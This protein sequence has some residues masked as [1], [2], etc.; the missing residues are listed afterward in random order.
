M[1]TAKPDDRLVALHKKKSWFLGCC[2]CT[3]YSNVSQASGEVGRGG[4]GLGWSPVCCPLSWR[5][6]P[7]W[8]PFRLCNSL[9]PSI[10]ALH[11]SFYLA[12]CF[13]SPSI[14]ALG[15]I[16]SRNGGPDKKDG[17]HE[18]NQNRGPTKMERAEM[19]GQAKWRAETKG[20][21]K[22]E[23]RNGRPTWRP[24]RGVWHPTL[25]RTALTNGFKSPCIFRSSCKAAPNHRIFCCIP[26]NPI[27]L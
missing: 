26:L 16:E 23:S 21:T 8:P 9:R 11:F 19:G 25:P 20:R 4:V 27:G 6:S 10:L 18:E 1:T 17:Q 14:S 3:G 12:L 15:K 5:G 13:G 22:M 24:S 2:E 7:F